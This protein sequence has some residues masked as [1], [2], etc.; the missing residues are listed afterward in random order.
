MR[1]RHPLRIGDV[2]TVQLPLHQ[3]GGH[4]QTGIRPA[5]VVGLPNL[6]GRPRFPMVLVVP[7]TTQVGQWA[8]GSSHLYPSLQAGMGGLTQDCIVLLDQL[9]SIDVGRM[10][11]RIGTLG[12]Q[13][14]MTIS[15]GL[16]RIFQF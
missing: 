7:T 15:T 1:R 9:R 8:I 13:Q 14:L 3:P 10:G 16:R 4:E 6:L 2:I 12:S 11:R 5:I